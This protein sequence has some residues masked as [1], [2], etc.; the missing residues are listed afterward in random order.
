M[1]KNSIGNFPFS[2]VRTEG[3]VTACAIFQRPIKISSGYHRT[4]LRNEFL[5]FIFS[6]LFSN[7][8]EC[9]FESG[10]YTI[11]S[12]QFSNKC[13]EKRAELNFQIKCIILFY[14]YQIKYWNCTELIRNI[15]EQEMQTEGFYTWVLGG[16]NEWVR[17]R[18]VR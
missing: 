8:I 9:K 3:D 18:S 14:I 5:F 13:N 15:Q 1:Q 12:N 7:C 17:T 6:I 16:I 10:Q 4:F 11:P 2:F